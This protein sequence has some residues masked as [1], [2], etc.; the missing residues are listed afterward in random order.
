LVWGTNGAADR[1]PP[2]LASSGLPF[3]AMKAYTL[4]FVNPGG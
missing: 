1:S 3:F 2:G 4:A